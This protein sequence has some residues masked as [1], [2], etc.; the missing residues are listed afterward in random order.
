MTDPTDI[1]L[2]SMVFMDPGDSYVMRMPDG[3]QRSTGFT[4]EGSYRDDAAYAARLRSL[5]DNWKNTKGT[6]DGEDD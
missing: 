5:Y 4:A 1:E 2:A 6:T 3:T